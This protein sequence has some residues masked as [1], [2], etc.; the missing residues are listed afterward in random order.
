[1]D[2]RAVVDEISGRRRFGREPGVKVSKRLLKKLG[3]PD[4]CFHIIHI[5][6]T[7]GKGS[8]AMYTAEILRRAGYHV[9]LFTSPH[10]VDF[11]E[12]I[13][14]DGQMI[15]HEDVCRLFEVVDA[16]GDHPTMFDIAFL[17]AMLYFKERAIDYAVIETGLGGRLDSTN[18]VSRIPDVCAITSIGLDHTEV[19]GHTLN[20][21]AREKTGI[22]KPGTK[23]VVGPMEPGLMDFVIDL[24]FD[25]GADLVERVEM[26][27][28]ERFPAKNIATA[29][30]IIE[31]LDIGISE[32]I[33]TEVFCDERICPGTGRFQRVSDDPAFIV[34]GAHNPQAAASLVET[35]RM[36]CPDTGYE[37]IVGALKGHDTKGVLKE[38]IPAADA[39]YTVDIHDER[40]Y[41]GQELSGMIEELGGEATTCGSLG[42]AISQAKEAAVSRGNM[43]VACGSFYLVGEI[44][45]ELSIEV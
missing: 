33:I 39:I 2:Y 7:N 10:L 4:S 13:R 42:D 43:L 44:L 28:N 15:S 12:R 37:F 14:V 22:V 16:L 26:P 30:T 19:L 34:D 35:L 20:I 24:C 5:A 27:V 36:L 9:G 1:M 18:A 6:G 8:V 45:E 11:A 23:A 17:M 25:K 32:D 41:S 3:Y 38:L 29:D 21:I 31:M 40:A